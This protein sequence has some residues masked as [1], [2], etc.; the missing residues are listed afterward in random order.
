MP[1]EDEL[2]GLVDQYS[3]ANLT[4]DVCKAMNVQSNFINDTLNGF[5]YPLLGLHKELVNKT[6]DASRQ[7]MDASR[8]VGLLTGEVASFK[9]NM[10]AVEVGGYS[11]NSL[12]VSYAVS[13][14]LTTK[15][16]CIVQESTC[17]NL[18]DSP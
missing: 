7:A 18:R 6:L 16:I 17:F 9:S 4:A 8:D 3:S 11:V 13:A 12:H 2:R 5:V 10:T 1:M 15:L 14:L